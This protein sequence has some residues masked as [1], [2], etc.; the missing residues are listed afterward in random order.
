MCSEEI[1][2]AICL[3]ADFLAYNTT[4]DI[5]MKPLAFVMAEL[6]NGVF[7][8]I[9]QTKRESVPHKTQKNISDIT[10][11]FCGIID[12]LFMSE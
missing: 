2:C 4:F 5:V 3:L 10:E 12:L 9:A 7:Y 1:D 11:L 8:T 6:I